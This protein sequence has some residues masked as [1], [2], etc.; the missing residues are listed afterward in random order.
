M[1]DSI[2]TAIVE[3]LKKLDVNNDNHWTADGLPRI[4]TVKFLGSIQTLTR[5]DINAAAPKFTRTSADLT[6]GTTPQANQTNTPASENNTPAVQQLA[7]GVKA[8]HDAVNETFNSPEI[9]EKVEQLAE[10]LVELS[11][12]EE[13][14]LATLRVESATK[15]LNNAKQEMHDANIALDDVV[16]RS[17]ENLKETPTQTIQG[18]LASQ[19]KQAELQAQAHAQLKA[20]GVDLE[21]V[22]KLLGQ[23][24]NINTILK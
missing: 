19:Q 2:I 24:D 22:R 23:A 15:K 11:W 21:S 1:T 5:E 4:D 10:G 6:G 12:E 9:K 20:E 16:M 13:Y 17:P 7:N 18:Y 8:A 14:K 3:A